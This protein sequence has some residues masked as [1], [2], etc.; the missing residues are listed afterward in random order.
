MEGTR[1]IIILVSATLSRGPKETMLCYSTEQLP[2]RRYTAIRIISYIGIWSTNLLLPLTTDRVRT[3]PRWTTSQCQAL[4]WSD[5]R[6]GW[7]LATLWLQ[8]TREE[9]LPILI[10]A[11]NNWRIPSSHQVMP[12]WS[13]WSASY[14]SSA[15][16]NT[17]S[18]ASTTSSAAATSTTSSFILNLIPYRR[19][20]SEGIND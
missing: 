2:I 11:Y 4:S 12:Q 13:A 20:L 10:I 5:S 18:A 7:P 17:S 19:T 15:A 9:H 16:S 1:I 8:Y 14:S 3:S 6:A